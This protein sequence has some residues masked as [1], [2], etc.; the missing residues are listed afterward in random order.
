VVIRW[1]DL[2]LVTVLAAWAVLGIA[3][4]WHQAVTAP[5]SPTWEVHLAP[6][7]QAPLPAGAAVGLLVAAAGADR[8]DIKLVLLEAVW[9]RPDLRWA[10]LEEWPPA[11]PAEAL[12]AIGAAAT[13]PGWREAW[14]QGLVTVYRRVQR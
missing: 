4:A 13:P 1:R 11:L 2:V 5:R 6:L 10:L 12:V 7:R 3:R 9:Q 8:E 14:R